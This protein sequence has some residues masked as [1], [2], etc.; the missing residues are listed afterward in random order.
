[1]RKRG[2]TTLG[3]SRWRKRGVL[4]VIAQLLLFGVVAWSLSLPP[5][6]QL[7]AAHWIGV[8]LALTGVAL[9]TWSR[10]TLGRSFT[11]FPKP[12][13]DA[14]LAT[15]GPYALVRH[16]IYTAVLLFFVGFSLI[17]GW[18]GLAATALLALL[19]VFKVRVEE[20][21]LQR[22]FPQYDAYRRRVRRRF[23][24]FVF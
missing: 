14:Q 21:Y 2:S 4:W 12:K 20:R 18:W 13:D 8:A 11:P 9:F 16:P 5:H 24:P 19:W 22:Q 15:S 7:A 23:V 6:P 1:L 10:R 17:F 3:S